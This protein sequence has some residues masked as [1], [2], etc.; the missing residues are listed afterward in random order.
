M[1]RCFSIERD[2]RISLRTYGLLDVEGER[3]WYSGECSWAFGMLARTTGMSS[4]DDCNR[5]STAVE[6]SQ[7]FMSNEDIG[8]STNGPLRP[9]FPCS[10]RGLMGGSLKSSGEP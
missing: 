10:L 9:A 1:I 4:E 2:A 8:G 6:S 5:R 7:D 3:C